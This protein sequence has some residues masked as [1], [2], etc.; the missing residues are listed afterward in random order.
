[1]I[2]FRPS[3][4]AVSG[5]NRAGLAFTPQHD[6][7]H[8]GAWLGVLAIGLFNFPALRGSLNPS[9]SRPVEQVS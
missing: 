6:D 4:I 1:M 9:Q 3:V 5:N 7:R 2:L 8:M